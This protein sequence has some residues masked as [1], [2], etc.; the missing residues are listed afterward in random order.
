MSKIRR[1]F[2]I[3]KRPFSLIELLVVIGLIVSI[4]SVF[5]LKGSHFLKSLQK[6]QEA[7]SL[8]Y[9]LSRFYLVS[10]ISQKHINLSFENREGHL[11]LFVRDQKF[12]KKFSHLKFDFQPNDI[13]FYPGVI[14]SLGSSGQFNIDIN[15]KIYFDPEKNKFLF[16]KR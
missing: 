6:N 11:E 3:K 5:A 4:G 12:K 10:Q 14:P 1:G 8:C 13:T 2:Q 7:S 9:I 15:K 16:S